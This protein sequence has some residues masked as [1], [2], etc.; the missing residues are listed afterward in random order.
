LDIDCGDHSITDFDVVSDVLD[1]Y[2]PL[3]YKRFS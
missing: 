3:D 1:H 2:S